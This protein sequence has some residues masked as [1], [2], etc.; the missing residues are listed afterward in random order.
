MRIYVFVAFFAVLLQAGITTVNITPRD[1][2]AQSMGIKIL[3]QKQLF[4]EQI[5]DVKFAELSD[6]AYHA[7]TDTL[8]FVG[9]K[10]M[11]YSFRAKFTD[12]IDVLTPLHAMELKTKKGKRLKKCEAVTN[13]PFL[14]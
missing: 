14:E 12:K 1:Y 8:Y 10:G 9:D 13:M 2:S 11:L 7:K 4:F 6:V 3:D 5:N